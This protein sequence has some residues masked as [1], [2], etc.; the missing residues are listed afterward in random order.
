MQLGYIEVC[1]AANPALTG[2]FKFTIDAGGQSQTATIGLNSCTQPIAV[3][4]GSVT[5]TENGSL[6]G[7]TDQGTID[8]NPQTSFISATTT[9]L[10]PSGPLPGGTGFTYAT[11][12]PPSTNG[13]S[14]VVT[15]TYNDQLVTGVIE[16]CKAIVTGSGLTGSWQFTITGGNGFSQVVNVPIGTCSSP[17]TVP[18]G[19]VKVQET[20][21]LSESVTAITGT[22]TASNTNAIVGPLA[23]GLPDLPNATV[24]VTVAAGDASKQTIVTMTNNSVRLKLCK[25]V[26]QGL[27]NTTAPGNSQFP[28]T[29]VTTGN[30][31]PN[32]PIAPLSL[33]GR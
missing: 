1:K 26:D 31:G 11:T 4:A 3:P 15:V 23:G 17:V 30:A 8:P 33:G 2:Q 29:F 32:G 16:V 27:T 6:T 28:F 22:K 20:G 21:D 12:V 9:A 7:L 19:N 14:G 10:G 5:V 18:A 24:V 13:T 25:Y